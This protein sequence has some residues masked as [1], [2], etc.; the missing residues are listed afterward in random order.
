MILIT[1]AR[2]FI[3]SNLVKHFNDLGRED[4]VLVDELINTTKDPNL[5]D[6]KYAALIDRDAWWYIADQYNISFVYHIGARTDT[7]EFDNTILENLNLKYSK[8]VFIYCA[9]KQIP[10]VYASSAATY[11]DGKQG[12]SDEKALMYFTPLNPYG[13]SKHHFDIWTQKQTQKPPRFYGLKFFNVYGENE[14]HKGRMASVIYHSFHQIQKEGKV[15]LF[16]SHNSAYKDGEQLRDFIYVK[17]IINICDYLFTNEIESGVYNCGTGKA[18]TF[19]DLAKSVF[20]AMEIE[21]NIEFI[22]MPIDI[23]DKY[24]YYT[25][26]TMKKLINTGYTKNFYSLEEGV[27]SYVEYLKKK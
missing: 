20:W 11:G 24:Q 16:K 7:T 4:L 15:K 12:Y 8:K 5:A 10:L 3:G 2:G 19:V 21:T 18:R 6:K 25:E 13:W 27:E 1:G 26:A 23:R 14:N 22:D 17:D 9:E